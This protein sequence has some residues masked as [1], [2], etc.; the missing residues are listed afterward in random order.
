MTVNSVTS[1]ILS[2]P[3]QP[4]VNPPP[5]AP[6]PSPV[7][8]P[9]NSVMDSIAEPSALLLLPPPSSTSVEQFRVIYEPILTNV[10]SKLSSDLNGSNHIAIL[11]IALSLPG[12]LSPKYLPRSKVFKPLQHLVANIYSLIGVIGVRNDFQLD[13]AG[14]IDT[15]VI[16]VDSDL[17]A[18]TTTSAV[19]TGP[20]ISLRTLATST[21]LWDHVYY[22]GN[23]VGQKLATDFS[24]VYPRV[25]SPGVGGLQSIPKVP[26]WTA[27]ESLLASEDPEDDAIAHYSVAVG[28]TFDH[29][30]I[31]HK[32]LLTATV[33]ALQPITEADKERER[34]VTVGMTGDELLVNKKYADVLESWEERCRST[35]SFLS[36]ILDFGPPESSS[37]RTEIVSQ[38]ESH[39]K[40]ILLMI[41]PQ[42]TLRLVKISDPFGPTITDEDISAIVVSKETRS[43]GMAI[44]EERTKKG[45]R[46]LEVFEIDVLDTGN[47]ST[48]DVKD[49]A[50]KI[51]STD[52]RRR[53]TEMAQNQ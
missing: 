21:R 30:H 31:G 19:P 50:S 51:S 27:S 23:Q 45:W 44:N 46:S 9:R 32:L 18:D 47:M 25:G 22:P 2:Y 41:R 43:G 5:G 20:I 4:L 37:T 39:G 26:E 42:L 1:L 24:S 49:F 16:L 48:G 29:L 36:A 52:I 35:G 14:G 33:L 13:A 6:P 15:R 34:V 38:L 28:G 17:S 7:Q 11:D 40:Y 12:L 53:R 8:T 10:L 3:T